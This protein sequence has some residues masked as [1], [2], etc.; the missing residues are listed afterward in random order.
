LEQKCSK[1]NTGNFRAINSKDFKL[2][3]IMPKSRSFVITNFHCDTADV[4]ERNKTQIRFIAFGE[5]TC[6]STDRKHHQCYVYF[7]NPRS[8]GVRGIRTIAIMFGNSH[9]E[10]MRGSFAQNEAYCGKENE[11]TKLGEEPKQGARGDLQETVA[12]I[13]RGEMSVDALIGTNAEMVHMYGR[14]LQLAET[15]YLRS[16]FRTEMTTALWLHGKTGVGKSHRAFEG[17]HPDTHYIKDLSTQW[18]DGYKGQ[19]TVIFNEYRSDFKFSYL[20]SLIDKWPLNVPVRNRESVPFLAK[21]VIFTSSDH[22]R[23]CYPN[24]DDTRFEQ[25]K[26]RVKIKE[27]IRYNDEI[28]LV[29]E[30]E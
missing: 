8:T 20:L 21:H 18:W 1:G 5:E 24:V 28:E 13:E 25:F 14:T 26:R 27:L 23:E 19:E 4:Y 16:R 12:M 10:V 3:F 17:Y 22:P 29:E 30:I 2:Q 15:V 6:P 9:V 11:L 7:F